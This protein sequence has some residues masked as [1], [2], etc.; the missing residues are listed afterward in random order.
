MCF[1]VY[2]DKIARKKFGYLSN[3]EVKRFNEMIRGKAVWFESETKEWVT[4]KQPNDSHD[5]TVS[6]IIRA[7]QT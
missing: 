4:L 5:A 3:T 6:S 1:T 7:Y 2:E